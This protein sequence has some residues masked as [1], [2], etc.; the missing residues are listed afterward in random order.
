MTTFNNKYLQETRYLFLSSAN[1]NS[2]TNSK[3]SVYLPSDLISNN[4]NI[5]NKFLRVSLYNLTLNY[6]WY[7]VNSSNNSLTYF[8]GTTT[9]NISIPIGN[10]SVYEMKD[11]L[12]SVLQ[13]Y[14]VSYSSITNKYT[15]TTSN[16]N[17]TVTSINA[18]QFLGVTD[19]TPNTGTFTSS[20]PVKMALYEQL[21][22]NTDLSTI[23]N[24]LDNIISN[25]IDSSSILDSIPVNVA[26]ND[27][28]YYQAEHPISLD[29]STTS[30]SSIQFYLTSNTGVILD[31]LTYPW[32]LTLELEIY[33]KDK[34]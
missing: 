16:S 26:P 21:Y 24:N 17:A 33:S 12:N 10:Y 1:R 5:E 2:G 3:W 31:N 28:I 11:Y 32:T 20:A 18:G 15:Y 27:T 9:T 30:F 4:T 22:L 23:D 34:N 14:T 25:K 7:N 6:E 29:I 8:N 13:V 19:G